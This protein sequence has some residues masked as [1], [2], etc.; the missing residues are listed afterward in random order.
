MN[1]A[2]V[3][4]LFIGEP[5]DAEVEY[6]ESNGT[7]LLT[8]G[9]QTITI[10]LQMSG[11]ANQTAFSNGATAASTLM[12]FWSDA[13][14]NYA[15][16][17]QAFDIPSNTRVTATV[18]LI[19]TGLAGSAKATINGITKS[20]SLRRTGYDGRYIF[21]L[22][23]GNQLAS[24]KVFS[25]EGFMLVRVGSVGAIYN[26]ETQQLIYPSE[27]T[28]AVGPDIRQS[29]RVEV[30]KILSPEFPAVPGAK[31]I[32]YLSSDSVNAWINTG[33]SAS[34]DFEVEMKMAFTP[35]S[36]SDPTYG[37]YTQWSQKV[38]TR[39]RN[40]AENFWLNVR[41][42]NPTTLYFPTGTTPA[43]TASDEWTIDT[44]HT[45]RM[46]NNVSA[47]LYVDGDL[48]YSG[49]PAGTTHL[50]VVS[51]PLFQYVWYSG[52]ISHYQNHTE[53]PCRLYYA[54]LWQDDTLVR[55]YIPIKIGSEGCLYDK[56]SQTVFHTAGEG[57][58]G[59]GPDFAETVLWKKPLYDAQVE[60]LE[61]DGAQWIDTGISCAAATFCFEGD[62]SVNSLA[63]T[64][65]IF[66]CR[67]QDAQ[68]GNHSYNAFVHNGGMRCDTIGS[69]SW[70]YSITANTPIHYIYTPTATTV[71][72]TS[73]NNL[74]KVDCSYTFYLFNFHVP[75]GAYS[76]GCAQKVYGWKIYVGDTLVRDYVP[77]RKN[78]VGYLFDKVSETLFGNQ[79]SGSFA[80]GGDI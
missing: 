2:A 20:V 57:A 27:G 47:E 61:S 79:G 26:P 40:F 3:K 66:G 9:K 18:S 56:V 41:N 60:Y 34:N 15:V 32:E 24:M 13:N 35:A 43:W 75:S 28:L 69:S 52:G 30:K 55:D 10:D 12:R 68:A 31:R 73:Q 16:N 11:A 39:I 46:T 77:V 8:I 70:N 7:Q 19:K 51:Y 72:G 4:Q 80:Y 5:F 33:I 37:V 53:T 67:N 58:F 48:V 22:A 54:K 45:L 74:T 23:S 64:Q 21:G 50:S 17:R 49:S 76:T 44:P 63:T 36:T 78:G 71:N 62:F 29:N 65:G 59:C 25:I 38:G 6:L 14:G 1:F 42:T